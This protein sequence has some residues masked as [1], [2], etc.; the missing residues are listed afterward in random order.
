MP[1]TTEPPLTNGATARH[2]KNRRGRLRQQ[3]ESRHCGAPVIAHDLHVSRY[4]LTELTQGRPDSIR[5]PSV[6]EGQ[7]AQGDTSG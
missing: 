1:I 4:S 2:R 3:P 7:I 5:V 6:R